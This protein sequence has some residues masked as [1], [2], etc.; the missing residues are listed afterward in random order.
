MGDKKRLF[1]AVNLSIAT[2]RKIAD[3]IAK[4]RLVAERKGMR[5][6]WV[7]PANLHIT[8][9]F[10][11]WSP[12]D[13]VAAVRDRVRDAAKGVK[14]FELASRGV[15]AFPTEPSAR[16]LWV[17]VADASGTL[18]RLAQVIDRSM[19]ELGFALETRAFAPH[20]TVGRVKEGKGADE[21]LAPYRQTDFG[22]SQIREVILYESLMRSQG[23]EYIP[24]F[25]VALER[26]ERQT[27]VVEPD[28]TESEDPN[29]G[30]P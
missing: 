1:L 15:G 25:R 9:K 18:A 4:M 12:A 13:V 10:L 29:G 5:V 21:V 27:R 8:L 3:T 23:S 20:L 11:G 19:A 16:V 28:S 26:T 14:A 30:Q 24:Q 17:G 2:T 7:P 6:G 22:T